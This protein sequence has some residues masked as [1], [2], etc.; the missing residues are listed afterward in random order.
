[1]NAKD[2]D[3]RLSMSLETRRPNSPQG[4]EQLKQAIPVTGIRCPAFRKGDKVDSF[5]GKACY[6]SG[7]STSKPFFTNPS[8]TWFRHP[9]NVHWSQRF[10]EQTFSPWV[11]VLQRFREFVLF[12]GY[13]IGSSSRSTPFQLQSRFLHP[14]PKLPL[15]SNPDWCS[16]I[17]CI[18]AC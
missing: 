12:T 11:R 5:E 14:E 18:D 17:L 13:I 1:M 2:S 10:P 4:P 9:Y 7:R 6:G 15:P 3:M 8:T 16:E